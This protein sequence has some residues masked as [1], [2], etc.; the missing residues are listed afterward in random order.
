MSYRTPEA[1]AAEVFGFSGLRPGQTP[2]SR[3]WLKAATAWW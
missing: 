3:R 2:Q 1:I